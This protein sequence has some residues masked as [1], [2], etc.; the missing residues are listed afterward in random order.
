[1]I[2]Q[3]IDSLSSVDKCALL[4]IV[5]EEKMP[6]LLTIARLCQRGLLLA[7]RGYV[8]APG[9]RRAM[10]PKERRSGKFQSG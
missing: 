10:L 4:A 7:D 6:R 3:R 8:P 2:R 9:V 1:M 5:R